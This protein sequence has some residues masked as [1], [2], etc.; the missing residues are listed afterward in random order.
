MRRIAKL[1]LAILLCAAAVAA[2][3][4]AAAQQHIAPTLDTNNNFTGQNTFPF[5]NNVL[6]LGTCMRAPTWG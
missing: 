6:Y 2:I 5:I 3:A 1:A 4:P